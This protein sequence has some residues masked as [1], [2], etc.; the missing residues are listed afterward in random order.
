[1]VDRGPCGTVRCVAEIDATVEFNA[2]L[3]VPEPEGSVGRNGPNPL[4]V[5][6][7]RT[8]PYPVLV[9]GQGAQGLPR[10]RVPDPQRI[11]S[12]CRQDPLAVRRPRTAPYPVLVPGQGAQGL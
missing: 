8:A 5:R 7:P 2:G 3:G 9:P 10:G 12:G 4:A 1:M 11:V 6:R